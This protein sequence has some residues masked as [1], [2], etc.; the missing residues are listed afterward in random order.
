MLLF[1]FVEP[2]LL[3][4]LIKHHHN[5]TTKKTITDVVGRSARLPTVVV[6]PGVPNAATTSVFSSVVRDTLSGSGENVCSPLPTDVQHAVTS[7]RTV[8][9]SMLELHDLTEEEF[10]LK[11]PSSG[12]GAWCKYFFVSFLSFVLGTIYITSRSIFIIF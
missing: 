2:L 4:T 12:T 11:S 6:R 1:F 8:I 7:H 10:I 3:P 5:H 9:G